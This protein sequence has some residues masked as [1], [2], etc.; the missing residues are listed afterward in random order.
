M[1]SST[2]IYV[3]A[4]GALACRASAQLA[5]ICPSTGV[6][7][8]LNIP[9][10]TA[11]S[12]SGDIFF[13]VSAP[14]SYEWVALG[15]GTAMAGSNMFVVYTSSSGSN[16][17]LSPRTASGH[18]SPTP[19]N[20]AEVE[21]LEGSGVTNGV[22]TANVKCSNCNSWSGGTMDFKASSGDW[23]YGY[24]SSGGPKNSDDKSASIKQHDSDSMGAFSW[25]FANAKGGSSVNPLVNATPAGTS[26]GATTA[27]SCI[28]RSGSASATGSGTGSAASPTQT[29]NDN[30]NDGNQNGWNG[31]TT[32]SRKARQTARSSWVKREE[33]LPYCDE[34]GSNGSD[35]NG[36]GNT[37]TGFTPINSG[38]SGSQR[39]MLIAHGVLA[40][41][42]FVI[43]FPAGAI[44]IR[45]ASFPGVIWLHAA[46]QV[47]AYLAYIAAC[48]LGIYIANGMRLLD[49]HHPIIGIV[50][51]VLIFFQPILG[52]LHHVM[53]KRY[54]RR[55][56]WSYSHI[57]IGRIAVTLGI[58]NGGLGL[59]L[60]S[61]MGQSVR[62]GMIAYGV[63]AA[64]VWL[65]W[66]AAIVV[67]ERR[68][69]MS[70]S[71]VSAGV[72][73]RYEDG[74]RESDR[75]DDTAPIAGHYAPKEH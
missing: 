8:K 56:M 33:Q 59:Q 28:P 14:S 35:S 65:A 67:G 69:K 51:L 21:L 64:L 38:Y 45:L 47:F 11:S 9:E 46:F 55:T 20:D 32:D 6:C 3:F 19:D 2:R 74:R 71:A 68:R 62:S 49:N 50:V 60:A 18:T 48:G 40:S 17:T 42:A 31:R 66:V 36:N 54:N 25:D 16:V 39:E 58:I 4:L 30:N 63:I 26:S 57:W 44:A 15:Q 24:Q 72:P 41:L 52:F 53:F 13:Q 61:S 73:P 75:N 34:V 27:T 43:L 12:G 29:S 23:I 7:Y 10:S 1:K 22:M 70:G 37:N 5:S